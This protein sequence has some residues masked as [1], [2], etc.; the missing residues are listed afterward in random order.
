MIPS[1]APNA[2]TTSQSWRD[3]PRR[4][5]LASSPRITALV[6]SRSHT[7]VVGVTSSN[8]L[9]AIEAPNWTDRMPISTS[10]TGETS[11]SRR[12]DEFGAVTRSI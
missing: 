3:L 4:T 12:G 10:Q 6:A 1:D 5:G 8:R 7:I 2:S 9:L 11:G